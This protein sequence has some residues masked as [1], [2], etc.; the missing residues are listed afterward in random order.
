ML[1]YVTIEKFSEISGYSEAAIRTK[2]RDGIWPEGNVFIKAPDGRVLID[3]EGYEQW[4]EKGEAS[5]RRRRAPLKSVSCIKA[6]A[7]AKG[8][9]SSPMPLI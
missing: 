6:N 3:V 7:V 9:H 5:D 8:S 4:V 1:K 2:R